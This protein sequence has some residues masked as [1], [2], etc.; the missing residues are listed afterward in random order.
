MVTKLLLA[1]G[2]HLI[3]SEC[4]TLGWT[5]EDVK[6]IPIWAR[7][8]EAWEQQTQ[9]YGRMLDAYEGQQRSTKIDA[10]ADQTKKPTKQIASTSDN[11]K[12]NPPV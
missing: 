8:A 1:R 6:D 4:T 9:S 12:E 10:S 3:D 2:G 11:Q 7:I 5:L